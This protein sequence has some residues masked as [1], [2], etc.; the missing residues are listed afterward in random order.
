[1]MAALLDEPEL[2]ASRARSMPAS[3]RPAPKAPIWR[4]LRREM[5]SQ[6]RCV[7]PHRVNIGRTPQ[8]VVSRSPGRPERNRGETFDTSHAEAGKANEKSVAQQDFSGSPGGEG[9]A[10][11]AY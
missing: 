8:Q 11:Q 3:V 9:S 10:R 1:M 7:L 2:V 5:P 4:K 6:K